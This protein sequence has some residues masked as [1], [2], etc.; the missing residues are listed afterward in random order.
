MKPARRVF[1]VSA[2]HTN[3]LGRGR[4][5]FIY[6]GHPD[7]GVRENPGTEEHLK[8]AVEGAFALA[9]MDPATVDKAYLSNFR[10]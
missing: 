8:E 10:V 5:D 1:V 3:F 7:H 2:A 9:G 4:P 6:R